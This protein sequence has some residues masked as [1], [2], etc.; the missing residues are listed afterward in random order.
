VVPTHSVFDEYRH[1][2]LG[3][4]DDVVCRQSDTNADGSPRTR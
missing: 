1:P 4:P 2:W 3:L